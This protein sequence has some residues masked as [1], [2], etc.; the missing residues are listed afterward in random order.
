[1]V[2]EEGVLVRREITTKDLVIQGIHQSKYSYLSCDAFLF[3][4]DI[5]DYLDPVKALGYRTLQANPN[6][7]SH[8]AAAELFITSD[9]EEM[10]EFENIPL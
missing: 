8:F 6:D 2:I 3:V 5:Q 10:L 7:L 9:A 4:D 1:M